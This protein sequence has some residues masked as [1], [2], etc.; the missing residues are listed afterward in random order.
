MQLVVNREM[1]VS[2]TRTGAYN[3]HALDL[4]AVSAVL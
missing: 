2:V 4:L 3:I 1:A